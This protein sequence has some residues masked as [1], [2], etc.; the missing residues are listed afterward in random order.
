MDTE[1]SFRH[2]KNREKYFIDIYLHN[3]GGMTDM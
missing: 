1:Q 2:L 3:G